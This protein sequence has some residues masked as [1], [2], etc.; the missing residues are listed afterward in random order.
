MDKVQQKKHVV[1]EAPL[2][3]SMLAPIQ[4]TA[5]SDG[6]SR[7]KLQN[8][9]YKIREWKLSLEYHI[10]E[11]S[12]IVLFL[13]M[14]YVDILLG[15]CQLSGA[16]LSGITSGGIESMQNIILSLQ[17][18]E[19]LLQISIFR[20]R[21]FSHWGYAFDT[22]L[23]ATRLLNKCSVLATNNHHLHLLSFLRVWRFVRIVQT[24]V[25]IE[26]SKHNRTKEEL[27]YQIKSTSEWKRKAT[28]VHE[29]VE[30]QNQTW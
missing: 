28:L 27:S 2:M 24:Y 11:P 19:L 5:D 23:I 12:I 1:S 8:I 30:Q 10:E 29:D 15:S 4:H 17:C 21:F 7:S 16:G 18:F 25:A 26:T 22:V 14:A 3:E 20:V 9:T 6:N 13:L